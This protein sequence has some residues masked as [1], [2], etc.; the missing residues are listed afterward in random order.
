MI[1]TVKLKMTSQTLFFN[2]PACD[3]SDILDQSPA[4]AGRRAFV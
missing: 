4:G 2:H 1:V 3:L